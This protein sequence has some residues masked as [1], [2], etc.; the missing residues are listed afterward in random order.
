MYLIWIRID[1]FLNDRIIFNVH[2]KFIFSIA[3]F[4]H[5]YSFICGFD[6]IST[7]LNLCIGICSKRF[8]I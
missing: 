6:L 1:R 2:K 7:E 5:Q 3:K 4:K 8:L